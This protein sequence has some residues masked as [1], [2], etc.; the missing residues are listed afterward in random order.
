MMDKRARKN[1]DSAHQ[2][3]ATLDGM[4]VDDAELTSLSEEALQFFFCVLAQ[5]NVRE[6]LMEDNTDCMGLGLAIQ[7]PE[8]VL[9]EPTAVSHPLSALI[10]MALTSLIPPSRCVCWSSVGPWSVG[11]P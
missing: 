1:V 2:A 7:R 8:H 5:T 10:C 6:V 4:H 11:H 3:Q 9:D